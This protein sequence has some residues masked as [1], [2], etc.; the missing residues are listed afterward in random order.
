MQLRLYQSHGCDYLYFYNVQTFNDHFVMC[1]R[2]ILSHKRII[3][4]RM[5][6]FCALVLLQNVFLCE[7]QD[8]LLVKMHNRILCT[9]MAF[10]QCECGDAFSEFL[11]D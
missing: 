2:D 4:T 11:L 5:I 1:S 8:C 7:L 6:I 3:R 10:L 9:C